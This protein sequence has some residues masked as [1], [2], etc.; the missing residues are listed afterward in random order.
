LR[1]RTVLYARDERMSPPQDPP[2]S[3]LDDVADSEP[4]AERVD[5]LEAEAG[6]STTAPDG[7]RVSFDRLLALG[8]TRRQALAALGFVAAGATTATAVG[9]ALEAAADEDEDVN[10]DVDRLD[11]RSLG[12][13]RATGI[14]DYVIDPE[15][16]DVEEL[17]EGSIS[18]GDVIAASG[19]SQTVGTIELDTPGVTLAL[20]NLE[21][22]LED[23]ADGPIFRVLEGNGLRIDGGVYDGNRAGNSAP[24]HAAVFVGGRGTSG[25]DVTV[26]NV[27][28]HGF[29][30]FGLA[31]GTDSGDVE[32]D[33]WEDVTF[34][35]WRI[36]DVGDDAVTF[37]YTEG[38]AIRDGVAWDVTDAVVELEWESNGIDVSSIHGES[39]NLGVE[40]KGGGAGPAHDIA[41]S[42]CFMRA[43]GQY[44]YSAR[45][46]T[47][48]D[49]DVPS[50]GVVF[51][52][53]YGFSETERHLRVSGYDAA[54]D[55]CVFKNSDS[56]RSV[57]VASG[58]GRRGRLVIAGGTR[59]FETSGIRVLGDSELVVDGLLFES[60][61]AERAID[62]RES[63]VGRVRD[64]DS[65][66]GLRAGDD[67]S[68][69]V[70]PAA[71]IGDSLH[72]GGASRIELRGPVD[73]PDTTQ[74]GDGMIVPY[75]SKT[76]IDLT[77]PFVEPEA[78]AR[79][80]HDGSGDAPEGPYV[81]D[82]DDWVGYGPAAGE[83]IE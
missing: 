51:T 18:A 25:E 34:E 59:M 41:V 16:D 79:A 13:M 52:D 29:E 37:H 56:S 73:I 36:W 44:D 66:C 48:P 2:E 6:F 23:G 8:L 19:G 74:D 64:L 9:R 68:V 46:D 17:L 22:T 27:R 81:G 53:C 61:R 11:V 55:G 47:L 26:R 80:W 1:G 69:A 10:V 14:A 63:S 45:V 77:E 4:L 72:A 12:A 67:A 21:L 30:Q 32:I 39:D 40:I 20:E 57:E 5:R 82:G 83:R 50:D 71:R 49:D 62:F 78:H 35:G 15:R 58:S 42:N 43:E 33:W 54:V 75:G 31:V 76:P 7:S 65:N 60:E 3:N 24:D 38:G 28:A 70:H